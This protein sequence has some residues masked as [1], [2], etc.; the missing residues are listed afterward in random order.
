MSQV[1]PSKQ[2]SDA[3]LRRCGSVTWSV[4]LGCIDARSIVATR[5]IASLAFG[6]FQ[7]LLHRFV[8][9][10]YKE[11]RVLFRDR[12]GMAM[13]FLMPMALIFI[14][15]SD[16]SIQS[17]NLL[18]VIFRKTSCRSSA[19]LALINSSGVPNAIEL[20]SSIMEIREQKS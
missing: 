14:T 17:L 15:C 19:S 1:E 4:F 7:T 8:A 9:T 10:C 13:M 12:A 18:P 2:A 3:I 11:L 6:L 16:E 20:P 5:L